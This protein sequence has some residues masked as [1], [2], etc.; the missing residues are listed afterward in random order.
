MCR[1]AVSAAYTICEMHGGLAIYTVY[2]FVQC[3]NLAVRAIYVV[4][5]ICVL[6]AVFAILWRGPSISSEVL[7]WTLYCV[8]PHTVLVINQ[9]A[10][11]SLS[12]SPSYLKS[13]LNYIVK[14]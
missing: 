7:D 8:E 13:V 2:T 10:Q 5:A 12:K 9:I 3:M 6:F 4:R 1:I 14:C 11:K